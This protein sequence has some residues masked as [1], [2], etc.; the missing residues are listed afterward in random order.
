MWLAMST[1]RL[2]PDEG[3]RSSVLL[4]FRDITAERSATERLAHQATHDPLTGLPNRAHL[5]AT[6]AKLHADGRLAAVVFVDLDDL[7][8][9]TTPSVTMPAMPRFAL[10]HNGF[11]A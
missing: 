4:W 10:R 11:G 6:V 5:A 1:R 9:S 2:N 7:K 8:G 3:D